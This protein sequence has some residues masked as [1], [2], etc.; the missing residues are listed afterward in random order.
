MT[1]PTTDGAINQPEAGQEPA[2]P[3][4]DERNAAED[5]NKGKL[6]ASLQEKA[7][8]VNA[9]EAKAAELQTRL[10]ALERAQS[11]AARGPGLDP[12]A[13]RLAEVKKWADTGAD[14]AASLILDLVS[15]L[16]MTQREIANLR[17][18]DKIP[19]PVKQ[20]KVEDHFRNNRHRLGD[21]KGALAEVEAE[22]LADKQAEIDRLNAALRQAQQP[23]GTAPPTH[24]REVPA[25][26]IRAREVTAEEY[27]ESRKG[28]SS[29]DLL[30]MEEAVDRGE[31]H[32][33][34]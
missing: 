18:I 33:R 20:K 13:E 2:T 28:L 7:A 31:I 3:A 24:H 4:A 34:R 11:P 30:K 15:E 26:A 29:L 16:D 17:A 1:D 21:V 32:V 5:E 19:D 8:R 25:S 14:P 27:E 6:I 9:A 12:R 22:E 23:P 10:E